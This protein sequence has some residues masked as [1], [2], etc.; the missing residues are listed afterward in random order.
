MKGE[1]ENKTKKK[2]SLPRRGVGERGGKFAQ[3]YL[4]HC[5]AEIRRVGCVFIYLYKRR[6]FFVTGSKTK[7]HHI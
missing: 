6:D 1:V 3:E 7:E 5:A 2:I 4:Q